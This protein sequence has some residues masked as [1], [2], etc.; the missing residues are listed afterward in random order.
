MNAPSPNSVTLL[1][2]VTLSRLVQVEKAV[3]S[4]VVTLFGMDMLSRLVQL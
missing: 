4:I 3:P 1:G 2:I